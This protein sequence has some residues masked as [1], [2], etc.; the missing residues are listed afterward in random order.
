MRETIDR[1][2][3]RQR[4]A[5]A[6]ALTVGLPW[7]TAAGWA[8]RADGS[9]PV[10]TLL[11]LLLLI[12]SL[13]RVFGRPGDAELRVDERERAFFGPPKTRTSYRCVLLAFLAYQ[14]TYQSVSDQD[15]LSWFFAGLSGAF[16]VILSVALWRQVPEVALTPAGITA[17]DPLRHT[18]VPWEALDPAAPVGSPRQS[19]FL[20]LPVRSPELVR[21][22]GMVPRRRAIVETGELD[23]APELLVGA[24]RHYAAH[25]EHRAAIGTPEEHA[26]LRRVL[27]GGG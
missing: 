2:L 26:R 6:I 23:V 4:I 9:A 13:V 10:L 22:R 15:G 1:A 20:R 17:G 18:F 14:L 25:P 8:V 7:G 3:R 5:V 16:T 19:G 27:G 12:W 24:V 11:P 21:H